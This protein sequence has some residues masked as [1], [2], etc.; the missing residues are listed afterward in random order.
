MSILDD[1][2]INRCVID[3]NNDYAEAP[4]TLWRFESHVYIYD[5]GNFTCNLI[6]ERYQI[7]KRTPQ[8]A[9]IE[10]EY[11]WPKKLI[12][13][14]HIKRWAYDT[15]REAWEAW[16]KRFEKRKKFADLEN[17]KIE[18]LQRVVNAE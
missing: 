10:G 11:G 14:S 12:I 4:T 3:W 9:W 16:L 6:C 5:S 8:G 15:K 17:R 18:I 7:T 2:I 13:F 1:D